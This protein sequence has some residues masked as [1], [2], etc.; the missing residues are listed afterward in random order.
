MERTLTA[1]AERRLAGKSPLPVD[2]K[3]AIAVKRDV[4]EFLVS[5]DAGTFA[6]AFQEVVTDPESTFGLIRVKRPAARLG[7][8]FAVGERFQ[9]CFSLELALLARLPAAARARAER[10]LALP[11]ATALLRL[12]EDALLSNYAEV[13]A[14]ESAPGAGGAFRLEYRYLDGTPIAGSSVFTIE[15]AGPGQCRVRQVFEYQEVNGV[16]LGTFQRFGLKY[17]DQVVQMEV[18]KAA[19]RAGVRV[20]S[21]TIPSEYAGL[22]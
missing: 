1:S 4:H 5:T 9:G 15:D 6:R 22:S 13:V 20:L 12:V 19:A 14:I 17:H 18:E 10:L 7:R 8:D 3:A 16:A 2:P 11:A 21:G